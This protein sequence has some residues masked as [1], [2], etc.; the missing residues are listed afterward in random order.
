[1]TRS[2]REAR[3]GGDDWAARG[4]IALALLLF[5]WSHR[6]ALQLTGFAD[7]LGLLAELP[8]RA[9][10]GTLLTDVFAKFVGPLWPGSTMWRPLPYA[11]FALDAAL[12]GN[13]PGAWRIT[14]LLLHLGAA[15]FT[16]LLAT[17][18]IDR[19]I[20]G[21]VAFALL[22]L[23]P[24]APEVT[25]WLVGRFDGWA[26]LVIALSLWASAKARR[27]DRWFTLSLLAA[28]AAYAS[29]E[30]ALILPLWIVLIAWLQGALR[31]RL[32]LIAGHVLLALVYLIWRS[33][34]F[35]GQ[36]IAVYASTPEYR[37]V[38]L[39]DR[40]ASQLTF[41]VGLA[42]MA[43]V[44]AI[45]CALLAA[46][47][48]CV[49]VRNPE[50]RVTAV[51]ALMVLSVVGAVAMHFAMPP[52]AGDGYRLYY[53]ATV[54]PALML[55]SA[56][57]ASGRVS[58]MA[59]ILLMIASAV[60]QARVAAEWTH[61]SRSIQGGSNAMAVAAAKAAPNDFGL[62]LM[63]DMMGHV[64]VARNAQGALLAAKDGSSVPRD[65]FIVF[66]PPQL[67]EWHQLSGEDTVKKLTTRSSAPANPTRYFCFDSR[68]LSLE[69]LGYWPPG[70]LAEWT[71][72]W[73]ETTAAR[74]PGLIP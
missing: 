72:R 41:A 59:L 3:A 24:W 22:L 26:T 13:A 53:L 68:R 16:G 21:A 73:R 50:R 48:L 44:A 1:M 54:G 34:L 64:P 18:L 71:A 6:H 27:S 57:T 47:F 56:M 36:A 4:I 39:L 19:R 25:L 12:W 60:W 20:A 49:A 7:D 29:K 62:V 58:R 46:L 31:A 43:P 61:A 45:T 15:A 70:Q 74:C 66:T 28:I 32:T 8:Q 30:S 10:G 40:V 14:N 67:A 52:G 11:S 38:P 9:K 17:R 5:F 69:D 55:A 65:Y 35:V 23:V 51:S 42:S 33:Q 63:P 2:G 37:F